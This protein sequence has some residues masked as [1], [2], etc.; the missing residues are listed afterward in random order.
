LRGYHRNLPDP[1]FQRRFN[2]IDPRIDNFLRACIMDNDRFYAKAHLVVAAI[3]LW[4]YRED[5]PPAIENICDMLRMSMEEGNRLCRKLKEHQVIDIIEKAGE[6]RVFI[7]D[8][9]K[10][11][12]LGNI[13]EHG[14]LD[15][16]LEK[17]KKSRA[18]QSLKIEAIKLEQAEKKKKL[19]EALEK[20]LKESI[21]LS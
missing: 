13:Q 19:H 2:V 21:K 4:E 20:K 8:H 5:T 9:L 14:R 12:S 10:I 18:E 11:E 3:R 16:E 6:A 15:E 17:Y 1:D 7:V